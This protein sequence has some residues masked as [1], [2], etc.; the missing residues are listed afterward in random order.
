MGSTHTPTHTYTLIPCRSPNSHE[1]HAPA[2]STP[3]SVVFSVND[4]DSPQRGC[5]RFFFIYIFSFFC[6]AHFILSRSSNGESVISCI[7]PP[8]HI[9]LT[10][11]GNGFVAVVFFFFIIHRLRLLGML[12]KL[13]AKAYFFFQRLFPSSSIASLFKFSFCEKCIA[14]CDYG[15]EE[16]CGRAIVCL[17]FSCYC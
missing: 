15:D 2:V 17:F 3:F 1:Q 7:G 11:H 12:A 10:Y 8:S 16:K 4:S 9:M 13:A 14:E 5:E 6:S